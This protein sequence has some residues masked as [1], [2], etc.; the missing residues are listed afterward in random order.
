MNGVYLVLHIVGNL[1][2]TNYNDLSVSFLRQ[3]SST[4]DPIT[5]DSMKKQLRA[6]FMTIG[7]TSVREESAIFGK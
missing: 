4:V 1:P 2:K 3:M 6:H 5:L 7:T